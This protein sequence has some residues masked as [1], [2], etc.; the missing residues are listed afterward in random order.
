[1]TDCI[2]PFEGRRPSP[3]HREIWEIQE[4]ILQNLSLSLI[5][6]ISLCEVH[7]PNDDV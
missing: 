6:L 7:S 5:S 3:H 1:M 4:K 2:H